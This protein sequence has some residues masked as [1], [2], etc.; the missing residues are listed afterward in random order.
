[1][2]ANGQVELFVPGRLCLF[3]E[4]SDWAAE[5]GL[6]KGYCLVIGTDQGLSAIA[7]ASEDFIVETQLPDAAG[8]LDTSFHSSKQSSRS[9]PVPAPP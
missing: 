8:S 2:N 1:M 4:H 3:G 7:R 6:H 9:S 5:F